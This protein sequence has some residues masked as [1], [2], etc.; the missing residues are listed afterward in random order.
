MASDSQPTLCP[1]CGMPVRADCT[2]GYVGTSDTPCPNVTRYLNA[3]EQR[4]L[5]RAL[6]RSVRIISNE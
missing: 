1:G 6:L 4:V 3:T 5:H 2:Q